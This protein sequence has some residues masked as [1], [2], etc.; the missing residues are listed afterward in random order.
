MEPAVDKDFE[1]WRQLA[2]H[3]PDGFERARRAAIDAAI[4][5]APG[6]QQE[7]LRRLQWRIDQIRRRTAT[8]LAAC[9]AISHM[10]WERLYGEGGLLQVLQQGPP[11]PDASRTRVVAFRA[12]HGQGGP[13]RQ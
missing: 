12:R 10:M 5:E 1:G 3:D 9:V 6:D 8:P 4:A 7:R 2:E 11:D 13:P